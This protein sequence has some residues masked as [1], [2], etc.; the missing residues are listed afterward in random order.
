MEKRINNLTRLTLIVVVLFIIRI[1]YQFSISGNWCMKCDLTTNNKHE[2][3]V[4]VQQQDWFAS[5]TTGI[6]WWVR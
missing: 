3:R 6:L 5:H 2:Y 4:D 1:K